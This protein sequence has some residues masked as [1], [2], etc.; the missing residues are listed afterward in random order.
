V[1]YAA[2][3]AEGTERRP[4]VLVAD[5]ER[6]I[7]TLVRF[8]LEREGYEVVSANDGE[9][10]LEVA[11]DA[12]PDLALLDVNMPK[13][14]GYQVTRQIRAD[15]SLRSTPVIILSGSVKEEDIAASFEAGA[16]DHLKKPFSPTSLAA[17]VEALLEQR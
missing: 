1:T 15:D 7:V 14:D 6:D 9:Q 12:H 10:A 13:L 4:V 5:N 16:N 17:R 3:D 11:R 8:K 2:K